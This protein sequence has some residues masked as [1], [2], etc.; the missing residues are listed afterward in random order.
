[1]EENRLITLK[2]IGFSPMESKNIVSI[3]TLADR[4]LKKKWQIVDRDKADFFIFS[5][6]AS[7]K[8]D[9]DEKLND[10]PPER[11]LF[12]Y[13]KEHVQTENSLSV[14]ERHIPSLS[15]L[16]KLFNKVSE[17]YEVISDVKIPE[18][19][20]I[21]KPI[22]QTEIASEIFFDVQKGLLGYLLSTHHE[23]LIIRLIEQETYPALFIDLEKNFY[24]S[25]NNLE[26][27]NCYLIEPEK[28]NINYC[29]KIELKYFITFDNL[30]QK[31]LKDLIWYIVIKTSAGRIIKGHK[32][33][34]IVTLKGWPDLRFF[35]CIDYAKLATFMKNNAAPLDIISQHTKIPL[36]E[37][38]NFYNACYLMGLTE[39]RNEIELNN[40]HLSHER[41]DLLNNINARLT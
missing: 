40:K 2:L 38:N 17:N 41:L 9:I 35:K 11:R 27:L 28:L 18:E 37:I 29:S 36:T 7:R 12:C 33:T 16:V 10:I 25:Q 21:L 15:A 3:I 22:V 14:D 1:M 34:D 39:I 19:P 5:M 6:T 20:L 4:A 30:K 24:Y 31:S 26:Q 13:A 23:Q 32:N 8:L